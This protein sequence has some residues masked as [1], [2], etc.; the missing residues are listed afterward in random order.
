MSKRK[1]VQ[2][3]GMWLLQGL[4]WAVL[5]SVLLIAL[6]RYM[7]VP[8]SAFMLERVVAARLAH[9]PYHLQYHWTRYEDLSPYAAMAVIASE[10]Q[11]FVFHHGFDLEAIARAYSQHLEGERLHGASTLTQQVAKNLFLW[12]GRNLVRKGLEAYFT[13][14]LETLWPKRRI[15]EVY[16][17]VAEF[18]PGIFGVEAASRAYLGKRA[19]AVT[20]EEAALMA[21]VLPNPYR[22]RLNRPSD[23]VLERRAQILQQMR[24]L[25]GSAY[26]RGL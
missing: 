11:K 22:F 3:A 19:D 10:D 7:P 1:T 8:A 9:Q 6:L 16:L 4:L 5:G 18:G 17:N 24:S 12:P 15:L 2:R 14:L 23:Y 21:A 20:P 25:S 13:V 26:L